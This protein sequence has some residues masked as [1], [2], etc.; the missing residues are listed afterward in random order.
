MKKQ[1]LWIRFLVLAMVI[2]MMIPTFVACTAEDDSDGSDTDDN[3]KTTS[4]QETET[5]FQ[6]DSLD[7]DL[8]FNTSVR[9]LGDKTYRYQ[10][11]CFEDEIEAMIDSD[12]KLDC[13]R[14]DRSYTSWKGS[15]R[16]LREFPMYRNKKLPQ[17]VQEYFGLSDGQMKEYGFVEETK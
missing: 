6:P 7:D 12:M 11:Y 16:Y 10:V 4:K 13:E 3:S 2:C 5:Q 17:F 1:S 14:W 9:V 15:L 8:K